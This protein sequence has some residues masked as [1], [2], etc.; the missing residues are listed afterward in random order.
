MPNVLFL[1]KRNSLRS[2]LAEA[3]LRKV[4]GSSFKAFSCGVPGKILPEVSSVA[5]AT[6]RNACISS[7]GLYT[8]NWAE[9]AKFGPSKMDYV[10]ALDESL[11]D[12]HPAWPGQPEIALW[13]Y[14]DIDYEG[15]QFNLQLP[16]ATK[17]LLSLQHRLEL[18]VGLCAKVRGRREMR[19][20]L[21]DLGRSP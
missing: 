20:D 17:M 13:N 12:V 3:A 5:L 15:G 14:P 18:L 19:D 8:K 9:F 2:Q 21:R 10:I 1:S 6:L 7:D 16:Q 4:G 11:A